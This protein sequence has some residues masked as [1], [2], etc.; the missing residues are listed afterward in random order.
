MEEDV[1]LP[2]MPINPQ[3]LNREGGIAPR[4]RQTAV[5][6][7][8]SNP[9]SENGVR[10]CLTS[11]FIVLLVVLVLNVHFL[12]FR[13]VNDDNNQKNGEADGG[14]K[15]DSLSSFADGDIATNRRTVVV[16]GRSKEETK[17]IVR[18]IRKIYRR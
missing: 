1:P 15:M 4:V 16:V 18:D 3:T 7:R 8:T 2:S 6:R 12:T 17:E 14:G 9:N 13:T 11:V 5:F 10:I